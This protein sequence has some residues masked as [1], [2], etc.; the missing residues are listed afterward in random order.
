V[1][2]RAEVR[3]LPVAGIRDR[4]RHEARLL[5]GSTYRHPI[6]GLGSAIAPE[7]NADDGEI[8]KLDIGRL[9]MLLINQISIREV[10]LFP[11]LRAGASGGAP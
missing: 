11:R 10:I 6:T 7:L 3:R 1:V 2:V 4:W 8:L 5:G 9:V